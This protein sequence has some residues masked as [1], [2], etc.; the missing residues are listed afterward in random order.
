MVVDVGTQKQFDADGQQLPSANAILREINRFRRDPLVY[1]V[2]LA[3]LKQ[4]FN[5]NSMTYPESGIT[6]ETT[7]GIAA[8][9]QCVEDLSQLGP[10]PEI[11]LSDALCNS[12]CIHLDDMQEHGFCSHIGSDESTPED[13]LSRFGKHR[14]QCA[15]N[16]VF[17]VRTAR[18]VVYHMLI[19]DGA[20]ERGHRLNLLNTA[21]RFA[22]VACGSHPSNKVATVLVLIDNFTPN[23]TSH[24]D[25]RRSIAEEYVAVH[26][27][28]EQLPKRVA[29]QKLWAS[30]NQDMKPSHLAIPNRVLDSGQGL[31]NPA[32]HVTRGAV[33][34]CGKQVPKI[35]RGNLKPCP[36]VDPAVVRAFMHTTDANHDDYIEEDELAVICHQH[37][38]DLNN[39]DVRK[40][41]VEI[42]ERRPT[43]EQSRNAVNISEIVSAVSPQKRWVPS[44]DILVER[45]TD[46]YQLTVEASVL[47]QWCQGVHSKYKD[48]FIGLNPI[49]LTDSDL[50]RNAVGDG[51]QQQQRRDPYVKRLTSFLDSILNATHT[52]SGESLQQQPDI[53]EMLGLSH[54][55]KEKAPR[56][57]KAICSSYRCLW[58]YCVR[59]YREQW[60]SFFHSVGLKPLI[61]GALSASKKESTRSTSR[62]V[63]RPDA[64][65][66]SGLPPH[67]DIMGVQEPKQRLKVRS[68]SSANTVQREA[69]ALDQTSRMVVLPP[70]EDKRRQTETLVNQ[71]I[72][73]DATTEPQK[74]LGTA[75]VAYTFDAR[76]KFLGVL[77]KQQRASDEQK[78]LSSGASKD[79]SAGNT[80]GLSRTSTSRKTAG[81]APAA[82]R[83]HGAGAFSL[84]APGG[85][86][87]HFH[88]THAVHAL[89]GSHA[90]P[91]SLDIQLNGEH[92]DHTKIEPVQAETKIST[93]KLEEKRQQFGCYFNKED[94]RDVR[95]KVAS[96]QIRDGGVF[97]DWKNFEFRGDNAERLGKFGRRAF[98]PQVREKPVNNPH[99]LS[100][101]DNMPIEEFLHQQD[102]VHEFLDRSL[103]PGQVKHFQQHM[104]LCQKPSKYVEL[105]N[106]EPVLNVM[107]GDKKGTKHGFGQNRHS[108]PSDMKL[109]S[110]P[111]GASQMDRRIP[112]A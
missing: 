42:I 101:V 104:P 17:G 79:H 102:R 99:G 67:L 73:L 36:A 7:E 43:R 23:V 97:H 82:P 51:T 34:L 32:L 109:F 68:D 87:G 92:I 76:R 12:C 63:A 5:G 54:Q 106:R 65:K 72:R 1:S 28:D 78:F 10:L 31:H 95:C 33:R 60:L 81:S 39:Q 26:T 29:T 80:L 21:F 9:R 83:T 110:R 13:R 86:R 55:S 90:W 6:V 2:G 77:S 38:L 30:L 94:S 64:L 24:T 107:G 112:L 61:P 18:E 100:E 15:E 19:D 74:T 85:V 22:G 75:E 46:M 3:K 8:L 56:I 93:M 58:A 14:E 35:L 89:D 49:P 47:A 62:N 59:P 57:Q 111:L 66:Y 52:E 48:D 70:W 103:P 25:A 53:Q 44:V 91:N 16:I 41:F 96:N 11:T 4:Q 105:A 20:P 45:E 40:M 27:D 69:E 37:Q 84:A 88:S 108:D 50:N 98:D 71:C